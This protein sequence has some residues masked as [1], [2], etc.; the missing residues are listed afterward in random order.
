MHVTTGP[1]AVATDLF[2]EI[3]HPV[4]GQ[5]KLVTTP[6]KFHQDPASAKGPAPETGQ[7]TEE[8][9]L[10]MDYDWEDITRFKDEGVIL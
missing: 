1:Q 6:V 10:E 4:G 8:I 7:H 5:M 9:L 3:D 2:V